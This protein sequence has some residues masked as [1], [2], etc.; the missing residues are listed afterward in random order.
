MAVPQAVD[1]MLRD[2]LDYNHVTI[3]T[4]CMLTEVTDN[5]AIVTDKAGNKVEIPADDVIFAI[6][7]KPNKSLA[8][9]LAGTGIE[10]YELGDGTGIGNIRT[11][12]SGAYEVMRKV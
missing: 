2:L 1:N 7:L 12:I 6:G 10:V 3:K 9:E 8:D 4:G 11:A 5:G